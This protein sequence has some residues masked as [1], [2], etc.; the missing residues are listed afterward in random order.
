ME[1][2]CVN[3]QSMLVRRGAARSRIEHLSWSYEGW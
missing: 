2:F 1:A 3:E